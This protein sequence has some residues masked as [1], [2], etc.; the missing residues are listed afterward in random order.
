MRLV[1]LGPGRLRPA[2]V[3]LLDPRAEPRAADVG[4]IDTGTLADFEIGKVQ[5][6]CG[7]AALDA[8]RAGVELARSKQV[9]ALVT[10]PVSK[11][12]LH[13]AGERV[14]GQ[15]ELLGRWDGARRF[16]MMAIAGRMRVMVLTR[17]V[18]LVVALASV[19]TERVTLHLEL[20]HETLRSWGF[21][22]PNLAL[23]GLN[24]HAGERGLLGREELDVLEPAV[25]IARERGIRV[26]GPISPDSVF[27]AAGHG[28][29]DA[30]LALYHDQAFIPIKLAGE[31]RGL[32]VIA[33]L[34]F[35]RV[36]PAHG[37]AF[38]IAGTGRASPRNLIVALLQTAAWA[39]GQPIDVAE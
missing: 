33:G 9:D 2:I 15:T 14:E 37:T 27:L 1:V 35:L 34:S 38:D 8:L 21:G 30:V 4:W 25:R 12:A 26:A 31:G 6:S 23:A 18:P 11:E 39:S 36:S 13:A 24:P 22:S 17:H 16:Q 7:R 19:T 3:A 28:A 32:T 20:L 5:A 29:Y 10:A